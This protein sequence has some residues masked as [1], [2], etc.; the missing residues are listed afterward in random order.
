[1]RLTSNFDVIKVCEEA[2]SAKI[3]TQ[4]YD[5]L[6]SAG[7]KE[8]RTST[9]EPT[10]GSEHPSRCEYRQQDHPTGVGSC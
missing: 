5:N 6:V 2:N 8:M 4:F 10:K 1:M 3:N 7:I 9:Y